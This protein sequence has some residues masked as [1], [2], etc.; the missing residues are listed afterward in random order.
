MTVNLTLTS[1]AQQLIMNN[2]GSPFKA[3]DHDGAQVVT[4]DM[5]AEFEGQVNPNLAFLGSIQF[6]PSTTPSG[7]DIYRM[8]YQTPNITAMIHSLAQRTN[9]ALRTIA[10]SQAR[11]ADPALP[12]GFVAEEER[13]A[14]QVWH[15]AIYVGVRWAWL[16]LPAIVL[17]LVVILLCTTI[18]LS[19][20]EKVGIWKDDILALLLFARWNEQSRPVVGLAQ[21]EGDICRSAHGLQARLVTGSAVGDGELKGMMI[22]EQMVPKRK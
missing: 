6:L 21:T 13:V 2:L 8:I 20:T 3:L 12:K 22:I 1:A 5:T 9:I 19:R 18:R 7:R 4:I 15:D 11:Q 14:G 16:A 10:T 17:V